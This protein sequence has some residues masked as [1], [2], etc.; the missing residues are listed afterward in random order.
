[1]RFLEGGILSSISSKLL[2]VIIVILQFSILLVISV[3][4][5]N[6]SKC[7]YPFFVGSDSFSVNFVVDN[8]TGE[9]ALMFG[10]N[11]TNGGLNDLKASLTGTLV[12]SEGLSIKSAFDEVVIPSNHRSLL[13]ITLSFSKDELEFYDFKNNP[14]SLMIQLRLKTFFGLVETRFDLVLPSEVLI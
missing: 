10:L 3:S 8:E 14:P 7:F 5:Y 2:S 1:M 4:A 11:L 9:G 6:F 12:S 13:L